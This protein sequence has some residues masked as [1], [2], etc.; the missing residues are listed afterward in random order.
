MEPS[1]YS[2]LEPARH[3]AFNSKSEKQV[4]DLTELRDKWEVWTRNRTVK[5]QSV[6][7]VHGETQ[8]AAEAQGR[9]TNPNSREV[10]C[11]D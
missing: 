1:A 11:P 9:K 2:V 5:T 6:G 4:P 3:C 8:A 7:A 10:G